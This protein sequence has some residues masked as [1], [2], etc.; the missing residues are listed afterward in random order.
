MPLM[1]HMALITHTQ[2]PS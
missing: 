2:T 1:P